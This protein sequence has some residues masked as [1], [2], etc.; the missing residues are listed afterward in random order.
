MPEWLLKNENYIPQKDKD[1]F[2]NK[3]ILSLLR[4]L[5]MLRTQSGYKTDKFYVNVAFKVAFT[6]MLIILLSV[7]SNFTFVVIINVYLLVILCLMEAE[8]IIKILKIS[9]AM[10]V[11]TFIILLP[12]VFWGNS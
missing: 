8:E 6:F 12:A 3:S 7:S 10:A 2:V 5:S 4:V 11:F 1:A 9:L